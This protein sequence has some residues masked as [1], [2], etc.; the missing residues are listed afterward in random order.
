MASEETEGT[1][2]TETA[3]KASGGL[4]KAV[5]ITIGLFIMMLTTQLVGPIIGCRLLGSITPGCPAPEAAVDADGKPV[6]APKA[7]PVYLPLDPPLVA[8]FQDGGQIRFLQ[9]A[10]ELMARDE[11]VVE[12]VKTHMPVVRNNLLMMLGGESLATL[13]SRDGKEAL[14]TRALAEVQ[15]ILTD[16]TGKPGV[17]D[18]Y[19]TSFVVQ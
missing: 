18:L 17:E 16:N 6:E 14:R 11:Q 4:L 8:S 2:A 19:F 7:P 13:T 9:V 3:A 10:V 1:P 12:Q 5:G 15:R